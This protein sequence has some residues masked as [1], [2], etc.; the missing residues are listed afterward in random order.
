M[1]AL[2]HA[3]DATG[4]RWRLL[5]WILLLAFAF[6]PGLVA[7]VLGTFDALGFGEP[8]WYFAAVKLVFCAAF[9]AVPAGM[10]F[11]AQ[12]IRRDRCPRGA[13][14]GRVLV[15]IGR[16]CAQ[17]HGRVRGTVALLPL[18]A[19]VLLRTRR[20]IELVL[21]AA[22][23]AP[24]VGLIDVAAWD[25]GLFHSYVTNV[26]FDLALGELRAGEGPPWQFLQWLARAGLL[27]LAHSLPSHKEYRFV[28]AVVP[29]WLLVAADLLAGT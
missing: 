6:V 11:F 22:G 15:R 25:R 12:P 28:F 13:C 2:L 18:F 14:R 23:L 4:R 21:T 17:A 3:Q 9:L 8:V 10:Y 5:P 26:R 19:V 27:L 29:F 1:S 7:D 20:R 16:L 24:V